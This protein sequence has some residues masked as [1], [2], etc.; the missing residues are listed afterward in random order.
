[1]PG[2]NGV[3]EFRGQQR[4]L[5]ELLA[6]AGHE[7]TEMAI[8]DGERAE[9]VVLQL[10]E[11]VAMVKRCLDAHERHGGMRHPGSLSQV[12]NSDQQLNAYG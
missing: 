12:R 4:E 11:P 10:E 2:A 6:V 8:D 7:P 3:R 9:A 1:M 5:R